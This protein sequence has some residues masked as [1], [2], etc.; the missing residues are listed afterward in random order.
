MWHAADTRLGSKGTNIYLKI[1]LSKI[2]HWPQNARI[3]WCPW[4]RFQIMRSCSRSSVPL[5]SGRQ[6]LSA[7]AKVGNGTWIANLP[8]YW[9]SEKTTMQLSCKGRCHAFF[10]RWRTITTPWRSCNSKECRCRG[11]RPQDGCLLR[12]EWYG[13]GLKDVSDMVMGWKVF[14][15]PALLLLLR[16]FFF[17]AGTGEKGAPSAFT[18][19]T[20]GK[21][22]AILGVLWRMKVRLDIL[23]KISRDTRVSGTW[24]RMRGP[25]VLSFARVGNAANS[26]HMDMW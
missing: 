2:I 5:D 17:R 14:S 19:I 12:C 4:C 9:S 6:I 18:Q 25:S 13:D 23:K 1:T 20:W 8:P 26:R 16:F 24:G 15:T 21:L 10:D 7:S 11:D 3:L 22:W